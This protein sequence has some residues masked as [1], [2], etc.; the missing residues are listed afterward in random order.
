MKFFLPFARARLLEP[1]PS[2]SSTVY[3]LIHQNQLPSVNK[4]RSLKLVSAIKVV[5]L[6]LYTSRRLSS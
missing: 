5:V 1:F 6:S 4:L 2:N 3:T